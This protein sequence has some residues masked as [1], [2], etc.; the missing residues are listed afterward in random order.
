MVGFDSLAQ[1]H[2]DLRIAAASERTLLDDRSELRLEA[3]LIL[4][5]ALNFTLELLDR[6]TLPAKL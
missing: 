3:R 6:L 1:V 4:L 5:Q 2:H